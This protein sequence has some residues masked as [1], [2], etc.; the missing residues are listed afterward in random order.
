MSATAAA[1]ATLMLSHMRLRARHASNATAPRPAPTGPDAEK[2]EEER[3]ERLTQRAIDRAQQELLRTVTHA[4]ALCTKRVLVRRGDHMW[5]DSEGR[6]AAISMAPDSCVHIVCERGSRLWGQWMMSIRSGG[7]LCRADC[8]FVGIGLN[9]RDRGFC[10]CIAGGPWVIERCAVS[11]SPFPCPPTAACPAGKAAASSLSNASVLP[12]TQEAETVEEVELRRYF[13][14]AEHF[15]GI[16]RGWCFKKGK[17][18]VGYYWDGSPESA[19]PV[20]EHALSPLNGVAHA[21]ASHRNP[22]LRPSAADYYEALYLRLHNCTLPQE[23]HVHQQAGSSADE[24]SADQQ[25]GQNDIKWGCT[26]SKGVVALLVLAQAELVAY[27]SHF[28]G[29]VYLTDECEVLL[30]DCHLAD[31]GAHGS[32]HVD[33]I[34]FDASSEAVVRRCIFT[35][36]SRACV[37]LC[38]DGNIRADIEMCEFVDNAGSILHADYADEVPWR[39]RKL[40]SLKLSNCI[41]RDGLSL[42]RGDR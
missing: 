30:E 14:A 31:T 28:S 11:A 9:V 2:R 42:W 33:A 17:H 35:H 1:S 37:A 19:P 3:K 21:R 4:S 7:T 5:A 8:R 40:A 36:N 13:V 23:Y 34:C 22:L 32:E 27:R 18:G 15:A 16:M 6:P 20:P 39:V 41:V 24:H 10:F 26:A 38:G 12:H 25:D 29:G